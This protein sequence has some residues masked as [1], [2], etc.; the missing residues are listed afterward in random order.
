MFVQKFTGAA[1]IG[2]HFDNAHYWTEQLYGRICAR[3]CTAG[4]VFDVTG[5]V[6]STNSFARGDLQIYIDQQTA[7]NNGVVFQNGA[8]LYDGA[9]AI[10]GNFNGSGSAL[11]SA[12]LTVT[13]TV[14]AGH[15]AAASS[16]VIFANRL[17]I[18]VEC[19]SG[20]HAPQTLKFGSGSNLIYGCYGVMDFQPAGTSAFAAATSP[21]NVTT[22]SGVITGDAVLVSSSTAAFTA[23]SIPAFPTTITGVSTVQ[24]LLAGPTIT[25]VAG[26][27]WEWDVWGAL[28]TTADTQVVSMAAYFGGTQML[29][30]GPV[31]PDSGATIT[32]AAVRFKGTVLFTDAT[33]QTAVGQMDLNY[34]PVNVSEQ[35]AGAVSVPGNLNLNYTPSATGVSLTVVGGYWRRIA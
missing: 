26:E 25:P 27:I 32:G 1:S 5:A 8:C 35:A 9:L 14:P 19:G 11:T 30:I 34:V 15:P 29:S 33:H 3:N 10:R 13:G 7:S 18:G 22:F 31:N 17:D 21:A 20:A 16:A 28:T 23:A 4:V 12:V 2:V 6:T 24:A